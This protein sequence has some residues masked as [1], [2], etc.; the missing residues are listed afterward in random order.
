LRYYRLGVGPEEKQIAQRSLA[1]G[2]LAKKVES[3][4]S[5]G[6]ILT[7]F[8]VESEGGTM[9]LHDADGSV[10]EGTMAPMADVRLQSE[11]ET[12]SERDKD[13][14]IRE[15]LEAAKTKPATAPVEVS[16]TVS[17]SNIT[18][19]QLVIVRGRFTAAP[20]TNGASAARFAARRPQ[21]PA[22]PFG[23]QSGASNATENA[24]AM[25]DGILRVGASGEQPFHAM[26]IQR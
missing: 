15:T 24:P 2:A 3:A 8:T 25:I 14:V 6:G 17:G 9:R 10:Y 11:S 4:N 26:P 23:R 7:N 18:S 22:P 19:R 12:R 16:F 5:T 21:E 13:N 20:A 1:N